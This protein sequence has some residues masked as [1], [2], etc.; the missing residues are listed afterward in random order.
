MEINMKNNDNHN[1]FV[2]DWTENI[3]SHM[4]QTYNIVQTY[5][6]SNALSFKP[7]YENKKSNKN[8]KENKQMETLIPTYVMYNKNKR[9]TICFWEDGSKTVVHCAKDEPFIKEYG[10]AMCLVKKV[11][12]NRTE[13]LKM[14]DMGYEQQFNEINKRQLKRINENQIKKNGPNKGANKK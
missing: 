13:F 1:V 2:F 14:V 10:V 4:I 9:A 6:N 5:S 8:K 3:D 12:G 11:F 7:E